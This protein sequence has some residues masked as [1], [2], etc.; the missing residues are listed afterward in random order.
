[1][2]SAD[3]YPGI[4]YFVHDGG[5]YIVPHYTNA[6]VLGEMLSLAREAAYRDLTESGAAHAVYGVKHY[7]PET[8][9]LARA[10]IYSPAVLL[11]DN[12]F[13]ERTDAEAKKSNGCL[14]LALHARS[15]NPK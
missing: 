3:S 13:F 11:G 2:A 4:Q 5:R 1:M 9:I 8:G 14:I 7:D 10:D 12:D 6:S 15:C